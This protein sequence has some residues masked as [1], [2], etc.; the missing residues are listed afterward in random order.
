MEDFAEGDGDGR[1]VGIGFHDVCHVCPPALGDGVGVHVLAA[2]FAVDFLVAEED[3]GVAVPVDAVV[4][5]AGVA[6]LLLEFGPEG[7]VATFIFVFATGTEVHF[8]CKSFH[9]SVWLAYYI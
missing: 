9:G 3:V 6:E 7:G 8:E 2:L 4:A 1:V 5:D